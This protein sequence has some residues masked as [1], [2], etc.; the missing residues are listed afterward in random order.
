MLFNFRLVRFPSY[1]Y[2]DN[3]YNLNKKGKK[4]RGV[5]K[6]NKKPYIIRKIN[7]EKRGRVLHSK[8]A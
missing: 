4:V 3:N 8:K 1:L 7:E 6:V 2:L 5:I